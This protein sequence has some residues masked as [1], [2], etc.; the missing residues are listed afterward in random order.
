LRGCING[1][2]DGIA[3]QTNIFALNAAAEAARVGEQGAASRWHAAELRSLA[4]R[5]AEAA[6][7]I[8]VLISHN[9]E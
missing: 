3:F 9:V 6:R 4:R 5:S 2:I 7:E 8:K 1:A